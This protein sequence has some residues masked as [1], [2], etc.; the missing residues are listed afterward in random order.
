MRV[1]Q[2]RLNEYLKNKTQ[3]WVGEEQ[4]CIWEEPKERVNMVKHTVGILKELTQMLLVTAK[5]QLCGERARKLI[6]KGTALEIDRFVRNTW[7]KK[8]GFGRAW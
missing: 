8:K 4:G 1:A 3:S 2:T 7:D 6:R 5:N